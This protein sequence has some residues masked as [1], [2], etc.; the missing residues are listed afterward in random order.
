[1]R[2]LYNCRRCVNKM[3]IADKHGFIHEFCRVIYAEKQRPVHYNNQNQTI[4]C[5]EYE[6]RDEDDA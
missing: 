1:M 3:E 6:E 4:T 5:D 2:Y